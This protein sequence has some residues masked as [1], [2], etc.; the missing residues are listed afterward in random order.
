[1][2][3]GE[4]ATFVRKRQGFRRKQ[5]LTLSK[6]MLAAGNCMRWWPILGLP[7]GRGPPD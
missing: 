2:Q 1:M 7:S 4:I 3:G 5:P 6:A